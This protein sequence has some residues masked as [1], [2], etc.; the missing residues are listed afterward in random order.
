MP[1]A[2]L[3][4]TTSSVH[5]LWETTW[6]LPP[7]L[8]QNKWRTP[9]TLSVP[10]P[11]FP[12]A[13]IFLISLIAA[14]NMAWGKRE[15]DSLISPLLVLWMTEGRAGGCSGDGNDP[16]CFW[17]SGTQDN[18]YTRSFTVEIWSGLF[19]LVCNYPPKITWRPHRKKYKRFK[20]IVTLWQ[21]LWYCYVTLCMEK[22]QIQLFKL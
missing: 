10:G 9:S 16:E 17:E 4:K 19:W 13:L 8:R 12:A 11:L 18:L 7:I 3:K 21:T 1:L 6:S 15:W 20:Q 2:H 14:R 5:S 22:H